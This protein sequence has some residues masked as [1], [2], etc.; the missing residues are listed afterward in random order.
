MGK[1][2]LKKD[3]TI[4]WRDGINYKIHKGV[5]TLVPDLL[6]DY[7]MS[8]PFY[9]GFVISSSK[10]TKVVEKTVIPEVVQLNTEPI[11]TKEELDKNEILE[12]VVEEDNIN[13]LKQLLDTNKPVNKKKGRPSKK[14]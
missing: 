13:I 10:D 5:A 1:I 7:I 11:F 14:K 6:V 12:T 9:Q 8:S 3:V 4:V 2:Q